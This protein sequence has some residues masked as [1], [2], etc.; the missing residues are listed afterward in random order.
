MMV[1]EPDICE[2][3]WMD[4]GSVERKKWRIRIRGRRWPISV[5]VFREVE[6]RWWDGDG[7]RDGMLRAELAPRDLKG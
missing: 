4:M 2:M 7:A 6:G 1:G 5:V 3:M